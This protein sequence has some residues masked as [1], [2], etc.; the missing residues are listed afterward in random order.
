MVTLGV[1]GTL[2]Y[3]TCSRRLPNCEKFECIALCCMPYSW[4]NT[5]ITQQNDCKSQAISLELKS[6]GFFRRQWG[7]AEM[8]LGYK[9][10]KEDLKLSG[11]QKKVCNSTLDDREEMDKSLV[12]LALVGTIRGEKRGKKYS[13]CS[14]EIGLDYNTQYK[15]CFILPAM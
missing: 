14:C 1:I 12:L 15:P 6:E 9:A 13:W 4:S 2:A 7:S 10:R 5:I 8:W 11:W 3:F